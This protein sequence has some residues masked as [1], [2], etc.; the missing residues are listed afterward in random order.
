MNTSLHNE[1]HFM[2]LKKA[3]LTELL[4]AETTKAAELQNKYDDAD[5]E[6]NK[7]AQLV[8]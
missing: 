3:E 2:S 4:N 8:G 1:I 6:L 5:Y 7:V